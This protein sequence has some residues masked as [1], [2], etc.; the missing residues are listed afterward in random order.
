[1]L[2]KLKIAQIFSSLITFEALRWKSAN[3]VSLLKLSLESI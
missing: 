3:S 2:R 1:M